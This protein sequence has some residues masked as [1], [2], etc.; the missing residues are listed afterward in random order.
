MI[1]AQSTYCRNHVPRTPEWI[2]KQASSQSGRILSQETRQKI[3]EARAG[4]VETICEWC[5]KT[6]PVKPARLKKGWGKHCSNKC[7]Y[8]ARAGKNS[9]F[10][11]GGK[12]QLTCHQCGKVFEDYECYHTG[13]L[14]FCC[15]SCKAV[16]YKAIQKTSDTKIERLMKAALLESGIPFAAQVD[17]CNVTIADFFLHQDNLAIFCDGDYW[18]S[19]PER[20][21]R[22]KRQ[23]GILQLHGIKVLRFWERDILSNIGHCLSIIQQ[24]RQAPLEDLAVYQL[25]LP[26]FES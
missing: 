4:Q 2:N 6:F 14:T 7:T 19:F 8:A 11:N 17:L 23:T 13:E 9:P 10:W 24:A 26:T 22:D 18:H 3:S 16:Y 25:G 20:Q 5:G 12:S 1:V 21:E 15:V